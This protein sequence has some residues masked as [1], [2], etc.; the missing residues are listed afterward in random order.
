MN[1]TITKSIWCV[2]SRLRCICVCKRIGRVLS[3]ETQKTSGFKFRLLVC[4]A[5]GILAG[6]QVTRWPS[7]N[8]LKKTRIVYWT[9]CSYIVVQRIAWYWKSTANSVAVG[10]YCGGKVGDTG[11]LGTKKL[12][13]ICRFN[14][15]WPPPSPFSSSFEAPTGLGECPL[16]I[17]WERH[18]KNQISLARRFSAFNHNGCKSYGTEP[19]YQTS[20]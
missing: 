8:L 16:Q 4:L 2:F 15:H 7:S 18:R 3:H 20:I 17:N 6:A 14:W 11:M 5:R 19:L 13:E 9:Q 10:Q 1:R 12:A